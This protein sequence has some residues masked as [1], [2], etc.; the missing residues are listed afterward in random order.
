VTA[1]PSTA[2]SSA[3]GQG[4]FLDYAIDLEQ[5]GDFD[6]RVFTAPSLD[7]RGGTGLRYAVSLD[8]APPVIANLHEGETRTGEGQ[9]G[10]EKAVADNVRVQAIRLTA[11]K[12]GAH[13]IRLWRIDPG[14]V[15]ERLV[16]FR[17]DLPESY[18]GPVE[19]V[20]R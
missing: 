2:P 4:P 12:A 15:F 9:K 14:V 5:A 18:L 6:L 1:Y 17:G 8:D 16:I 13:R 11:S 20:R 19:G 10:W 7:F 3:P